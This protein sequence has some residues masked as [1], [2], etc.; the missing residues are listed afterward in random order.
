MNRVHILGVPIDAMTLEEAV[1]HI[2]GFLGSTEK[3]HVATPN[4]EMLVEANANSAFKSLLQKTDLNLPDSSGLLWAAKKTGQHLLERVAG[5]D[6]VERL[7]LRLDGSCPV[8]F[9]G[10]RNGAGAKA[11]KKIQM[12]NA[13][14]KITTFEGSPSKE[15]AKEIIQKINDSGAHL[16]LV[17]YGA[18]KQD[19]WINQYLMNLTSVR[20]AMGVGGTFDFL[21]GSIKRAPKW[22]RSLHLEW[23][24]R[25]I[26]QPSRIIRI[27][28]AV[29]VFPL[30]VRG[31][32]R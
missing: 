15:D 14:C 23:L 20:V 4:S 32:S 3:K 8:F 16:L 22:M 29:V 17:A 30:L 27:W 6:A 25:F 18:P 11:A 28:R 26:L 24:Y 1:D 2:R 5:V 21:S 9:L 10:G 12:Q 31:D 7:L 19:L 13:K